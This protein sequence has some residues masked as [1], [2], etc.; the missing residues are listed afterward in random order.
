MSNE[1]S[2]TSLATDETESVTASAPD[3]SGHDTVPSSV[4]ETRRRFGAH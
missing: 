3:R 1:E 2:V 4:S